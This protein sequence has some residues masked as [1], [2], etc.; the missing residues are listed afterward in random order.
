MYQGGCNEF[1]NLLELKMKYKV[2]FSV[3]Y[4]VEIDCDR[5]DLADEISNLNIPEDDQTKY[6]TDTF[7]PV[8]IEDENGNDIDVTEA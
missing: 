4:E 6:V 5:A 1:Q 8:S 3:T 7:E 2:Q